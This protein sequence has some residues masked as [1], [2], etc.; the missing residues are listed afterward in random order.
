MLKKSKVSLAEVKESVQKEQA[1]KKKRTEKDLSIKERELF[2]KLY[3][4]TSNES[5]AK[6]FLISVDD[7]ERLAHETQVYKDPSYTRHQMSIS[8]GG[9]LNADGMQTPGYLITA[10]TKKMTEEERRE[11][12]NIYEEGIN[13]TEMLQELAIAQSV[14]IQ[15]GVTIEDNSGALYR[16]VNDAIDSLHAILRSMHELEHGEKHI[17]ELGNTWEQMILRSNQK[18]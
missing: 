11:I 9:K 4:M 7:V 10:I 15:R 14:R 6:Q 1:Y 17:H 3:P 5:L 12:I 8:K 2:E 16:V 13:P 18:K